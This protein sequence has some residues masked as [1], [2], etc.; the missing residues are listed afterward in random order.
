MVNMFFKLQNIK[1]NEE[2]K[3]FEDYLYNFEKISPFFKWHPLNDWS[4]CIE[5]RLSNYSLRQE[6]AEILYHQNQRWNASNKTFSYIDKL[7]APNA[8]AI[9]TGQQAGI[10]GGPLYTIYKILSV[11]KLVEY[12]QKKFDE[13]LFVPIFWM[14]VGDNDYREINHFYFFTVNNELERLSLSELPDDYRSVA[15]RKI[16]SEITEIHKRLYEISFPSEFRDQIIDNLKRIYAEGKSFTIA[17]AELLHHLFGNYGLIVMDPT[18]EKVARLAK[19]LYF[20]V[21]QKSEKINNLFERHSGHLMDR[22]YH[23]QITL[24]PGQSLLFI[25]NED[26]ARSKIILDGDKGIIQNPQ[27]KTQIFRND[28]F[29]L[30]SQSPDK[31]TP[32]VVLRP[33]LQDFLLPTAA[34]IGGPSEISYAAQLQPIYQLLKVVE[35]IF[36]PR[37]RITVV[38]NKIQKIINKFELDFPKILAFRERFID[39][40]LSAHTDQKVQKSFKLAE[41]HIEKAIDGL[42]S[43]LLQID[44][45]LDSSIAKTEKSMIDFL[46]KLKY[47][48]EQFNKKKLETEIDQ[49][50]KI[51]LN[52]FPESEYQE[53]ILNSFYFQIKYGPELIDKIYHTM[54]VLKWDHQ[55]ILM[56]SS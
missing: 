17:F 4:A 33:V 27:K 11:I 9:V 29:E 53:R 8:V 50:N 1:L 32:N 10:F 31:F 15:L 12:I 2:P 48:A 37:T 49:I 18:E 44:R 51:I 19:P 52:L 36:Y 38:E 20:T 39:E 23:S 25:E 46:A 47:R 43:V 16:P 7:K 42:R 21:L 26:K 13:W 40:F 22:G 28:L 34:Y 3:L 45:T 35:P 41:Q 54:D 56:E 14:E 5:E 24:E 55:L 6:I 30:L